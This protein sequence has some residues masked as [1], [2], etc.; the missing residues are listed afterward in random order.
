MLRALESSLQFGRMKKK[1][2]ESLRGA[3]LSA[4][5][6]LAT[7]AVDLWNEKVKKG[8]VSKTDSDRFEEAIKNIQMLKSTGKKGP[9]KRKVDH[10]AAKHG[11]EIEAQRAKKKSRKRTGGVDNELSNQERCNNEFLWAKWQGK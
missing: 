7:A 2:I 3:A 5:K 10:D 4:G 6:I 11:G 1:K 8:K 9:S